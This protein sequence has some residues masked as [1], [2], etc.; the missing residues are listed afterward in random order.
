MDGVNKL[1]EEAAKCVKCGKC[2]GVCPTYNVVRREGTS[3]RG[4]VALINALAKGEE[5]FGEA[6]KRDIKD[7]T[8]CASCH[9]NCPN[10]VNVP[11]LVIGARVESAESNGLP[12]IASFIYKKL[13]ASERLMPLAMKAASR[14]KGLVLKD[15]PLEDGLV[16]R[17]SLPLIGGGRLVPELAEEFFLDRDEVR[18][19]STEPMP[20][21]SDV[22]SIKTTKVAFFSGCG[23]NYLMPEVG[24][25]T[26]KVLDKAGA[27]VSVPDRQLCCGMP[28]L[29]GGDK[30]T[31][32]KLALSNLEAF[33]AGEYDFITTSC[34]TCSHAL[35]SVFG[36][37]LAD[38]G[39]E[40]LERV[41]KFSSKV[42]DVT[43]LLYNEL[44]YRGEGAK[45]DDRVVTWHDP[46]HLSRCQGIREEPRELLGVSGFN[47]KGMK[48]PCKCCGLGGGLAFTNYELSRE[49]SRV[50]AESIFASGADIV[51]TA[52]PGCIVQLRDSLHNFAEDDKSVPRVLH[53]VELL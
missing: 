36:K 18:R 7:C 31:A 10:D 17:F 24:L 39:P 46:C 28:A 20:R 16:S 37:V 1:I 35:K 41:E 2:K 38:E 33:E 48:N 47:F 49:V 21:K 51:A 3:P 30:K 22:S 50:K 5:G 15:A 8:L 14:L 40:V 25:A 52:C 27:S 43:E 23:I 6:Y 45:R 9:T 42:R 12:F 11:E 19:L 26:L 4:R 53:L 34:A 13:L 32:K 44:G 29:S